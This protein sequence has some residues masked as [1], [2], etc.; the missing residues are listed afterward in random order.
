MKKT[1]AF[2]VLATGAAAIGISVAPLA[3]ADPTTC[4]T[5]GATTVCGQG[6]VNDGGGSAP[7]PAAPAPTPGGCTTPYGTYQNCNNH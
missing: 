7:P 5:V 6:S 4:E 3:P 2:L 1:A